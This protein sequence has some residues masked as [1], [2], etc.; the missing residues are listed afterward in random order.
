MARRD[1]KLVLGNQTD[2]IELVDLTVRRKLHGLRELEVHRRVF[3][4]GKD[5]EIEIAGAIG[6]E[7]ALEADHPG[8][9]VVEIV[10]EKFVVCC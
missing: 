6:R 8:L 2:A 10:V 3:A 4:Q 1:H 9:A 5:A 7:E